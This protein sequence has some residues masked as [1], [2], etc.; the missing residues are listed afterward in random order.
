MVKTKE[1]NREEKGGIITYGK[2]ILKLPK[3]RDKWNYLIV[4]FVHLLKDIMKEEI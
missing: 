4:Q 2:I 3:L 1:L